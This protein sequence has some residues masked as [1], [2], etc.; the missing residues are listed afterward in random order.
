MA[1]AIL[2]AVMVPILKALTSAQV[3]S[4]IIERRTRSLMLAQGKLDEIQ[5]SSLHHYDDSFAET[6]SSLG[7]SYLCR[8]I[9]SAVSAN[10][11]NIKV[12]VGCDLNDNATLDAGE[13]EVTLATLIARRW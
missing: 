8:V 7:G 5:A 10:I 1:S 3:S 9:D 6:N 2:I 4:T 11:R 12:L 13:I